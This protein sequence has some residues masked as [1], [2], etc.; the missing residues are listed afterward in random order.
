M[1]IYFNG[2]SGL[3]R[4]L[5]RSVYTFV[6]TLCIKSHTYLKISKIILNFINR[7]NLSQL[8]FFYQLPKFIEI[9]SAIIFIGNLAFTLV[10]W[11]RICFIAMM[12]K[13]RCLGFRR[14]LNRATR[15]AGCQYPIIRFHLSHRKPNSKNDHL[16]ALMSY[17]FEYE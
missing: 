16:C 15:S 4:R 5:L 7:M 1:V 2:F 12:D 8:T 11:H 17:E 6:K 10:S 9:I 13:N 14:I 3:L